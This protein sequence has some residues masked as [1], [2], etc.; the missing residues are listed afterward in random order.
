[1]E[2]ITKPTFFLIFFYLPALVLSGETRYTKELSPVL[3]IRHFSLW[4]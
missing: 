1:M 2:K 3:I 4:A